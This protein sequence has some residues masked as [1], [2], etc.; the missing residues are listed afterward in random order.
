MATQFFGPGQAKPDTV[1]V[2]GM[3][4]VDQEAPAFAVE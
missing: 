3:V 4:E 1:V 2:A